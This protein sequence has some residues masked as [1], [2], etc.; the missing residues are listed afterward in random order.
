VPRDGLDGR[1]FSGYQGWF[2]TP[3][4]GSERGWAHWTKKR[5]KPFDLANAKVDLWPDVSELPPEER[6]AA[7]LRL[8]DGRPA[9][10]FSS[11]RAGTVLRHWRWMREYG[12]DGAFVQ[13][14]ITDLKDRREALHFNRVLA[15]CRDGARREGRLWAVM[16]DLTGLG[17]GRTGEVLAD[18]RVLAERLRVAE[19]PAYLRVRGKP[20][21]AVWGVGFNDRRAYSLSECSDLVDGLRAANLSVLLGVPTGWRTLDRDA[22]PDPELHGLLRRTDAISPWTVGRY[23]DP[24][25]AARH[26]ERDWTADLAWCREAKVDYLPVVFPGF[27]WHHMHGGP[28]DQIP[29]L[30]GRF[31]RAQ[32][33]AAHK[34]GLKSAYVA[35]FD[36]VDEATAIFKTATTPPDGFLGADG[37]PPDHYLKLAGEGGRL[38]RGE[39]PPVK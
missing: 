37:V 13:R 17:V 25:E 32:F 20:L 19:D 12:L 10:V 6:F 23:R 9:E 39:V 29:R 11:A 34:A 15:A 8:P 7:E 16:Y 31:F 30:Q 1:V 24:K 21:V 18:W 14:F 3:G 36:E 28:P 2:S 27:S 26:G 5:S 22:A 33:E 38:L 35:M 4:D